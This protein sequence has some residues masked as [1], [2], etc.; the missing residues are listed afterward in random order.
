V[1]KLFFASIFGI[2]VILT[3]QIA[4]AQTQSITVDT[5]IMNDCEFYPF[6]SSNAIY[7]GNNSAFGNIKIDSAYFEDNLRGIYLSAVDY[8]VIIRLFI[9]ILEITSICFTRKI[10]TKTKNLMPTFSSSI[11]TWKAIRFIHNHLPMIV[12]VTEK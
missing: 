7:A 1:K 3:S 5:T 10:L 6:S 2:P 9:P 8:P 11:K 12:Y 4:N